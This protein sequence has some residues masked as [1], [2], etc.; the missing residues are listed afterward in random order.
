[1]IQIIILF[2]TLSLNDSL[3]NDFDF[4]QILFSQHIEQDFKEGIDLKNEFFPSAR[5]YKVLDGEF[6]K[7]DLS[8][9]YIVKNKYSNKFKL[10]KELSFIIDEFKVMGLNDSMDI[11]Y[12]DSSLPKKHDIVMILSDDISEIK[13]NDGF[14]IEI[15]DSIIIRAKNKNGLIYALR[16]IMQ[17]LTLYGNMPKG[18]MIDYP[19]V[20]ERA[21]H[22]D[23]GRKYF[24]PAW[25]KN[26]IR[27]MS[28]H[29]LN[30]LQVHF[31][32]NEGFRLECETYPEIVSDD[33][34]TKKEMRE[35][36]QE[37]EKYGIQIIPSFD[38]PGHMGQIL[39]KHRELALVNVNGYINQRAID[40]NKDEARQ[41]VKN[42]I[43]EYAELFSTSKYFHIGGDEFIDFNA[44]HTY[45]SLIE[46]GKKYTP[47][48][49]GLD[50]YTAYI[51]EIADYT[52][53]LGFTP[54]IW[55][56]GVYRENMISNLALNDYIQIE[57][58]SRWDVN[59]ASTKTFMD[60]KHTLINVS[61]MM[62]YILQYESDFDPLF[63]FEQIYENWDAGT[64]EGNQNYPLPNPQILG[65]CYAIW[66]DYPDAQTEEEI[67][68][69]IYYPLKAMAEKS[70]A[71][72]REEHDIDT[73][74]NLIE[75][76]K[77]IPL[78]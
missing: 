13:G 9:I 53:N 7:E 51:N 62:Y 12:S 52:H 38:N 42:I 59:M 64:F 66:C 8:R 27:E 65:A 47:N 73:F 68:K 6:D 28:F 35:I 67:S 17:H 1:M 30:T 55:N 40:I 23:I 61:E 33:F 4:H 78:R 56:D 75:E 21:V 45:P 32:E 31:S 72:S 39:K 15:G 49:N 70:W 36:I 54:R 71:G 5:E 60:K 41:F 37:A 26:F 11:V 58:W 19:E 10:D 43:K 76:L 20:E 18:R 34:I 46:Y 29:R 44:F 24:T 48:A 77:T 16:A 3:I 22:I 25:L 14:I 69:G 63:D 57:Y 74:K 50:G 2:I